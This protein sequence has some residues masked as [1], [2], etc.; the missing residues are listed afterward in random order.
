[1][2]QKLLLAPSSPIED[3]YTWFVPYKLRLSDNKRDMFEKQQIFLKKGQSTYFQLGLDG[4]AE[5]FQTITIHCWYAD[6]P[7]FLCFLFHSE[8]FISIVNLHDIQLA[9]RSKEEI[10]VIKEALEEIIVFMKSLASA[11]IP[12]S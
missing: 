4:V 5:F 3:K 8:W 11:I 7:L 2:G 10:I 12:N 9:L 6:Y 1:M